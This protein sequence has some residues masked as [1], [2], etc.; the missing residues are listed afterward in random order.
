MISSQEATFLVGSSKDLDQS[1]ADILCLAAKKRMCRSATVEQ[2]AARF[3]N[4]QDFRNDFVRGR[5]AISEELEN[6]S[7][8][9]TFTPASEVEKVSS[10]GFCVYEKAGLLP[11]STIVSVF[12]K[13]PDFG[14]Y[15]R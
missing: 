15:S 13:S 2:V 7:I 6:R 3:A 10:Y 8:L 14:D 9:S 1:R 12:K 5:S 11:E 4:E